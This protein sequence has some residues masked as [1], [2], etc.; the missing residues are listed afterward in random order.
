MPKAPMSSDDY[1]KG[2]DAAKQG[3]YATVLKEFK[4]LAER[5]D[6]SAQNYLGEIYIHGLGV[7]RDDKTAVKWFTLA[8]EQGHAEAQNNLAVI[9][10]ERLFGVG[11]KTAVKWYTLAAKQGYAPAQ[12]GL[13]AMYDNGW[14]IT[15]DYKIAAKWYAHAA[16]QGYAPAQFNLGAM[17]MMGKG[18]PRDFTLALMWYIIA[19]TQGHENARNSR[20]LIEDKLPHTQIETAQRL[21]REWVEK[22]QE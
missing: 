5:G 8:A 18:T 11:Y 16:E 14:G 13:G 1:Q 12:L 10:S 15:R 21:A 3:D 4:P 17:N 2:L 22:H 20:E 9:S 7:P 6:A 19:D